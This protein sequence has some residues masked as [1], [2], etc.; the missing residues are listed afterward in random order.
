MLDRF[1]QGKKRL[2]ATAEKTG[3]L[4][5]IINLHCK[6]SNINAAI[7][8]PLAFITFFWEKSN[9]KMRI[10]LINHIIATLSNFLRT[11]SIALREN[12]IKLLSNFMN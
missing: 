11:L 5:I 1:L 6:L 4:I 3:N 10:L 7:V 9:S 2:L 12:E 8:I